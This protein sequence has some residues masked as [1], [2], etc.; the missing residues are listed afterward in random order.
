MLNLVPGRLQTNIVIPISA[1]RCKVIF[2]YYYDEAVL[3]NED[4]IL[5]EI[6]YSD[7]VQQE[8]V[9]I[10]E[11]VQ[12]G[13]QSR[14]YVQGRFSVKREAGVYHFQT[15]LKQRYAALMGSII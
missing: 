1:D 12:Q 10:C 13:L 3:A 11:Q 6:A 4:A 2:D 5:S 8:D 15:L 14:V 9:E 7:T